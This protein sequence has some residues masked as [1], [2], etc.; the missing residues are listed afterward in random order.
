[1]LPD[2][3]P[4]SCKP[5]P[6]KSEEDIIER[7]HG[8]VKYWEVLYEEDNTKVVRGQ[9]G[10]LIPYWESV[11]HNPRNPTYE[12]SSASKQGFWP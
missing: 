8:F 7:N 12:T 3:K 6:I 5:N 11:L 10:W 4:K 2:G 9:Y 1:M